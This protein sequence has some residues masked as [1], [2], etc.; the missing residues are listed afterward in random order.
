MASR[1]KSQG[2]QESYK[3]LRIQ[4][5]KL[6]PKSKSSSGSLTNQSKNNHLENDNFLSSNSGCETVSM[7]SVEH[8]STSSSFYREV[9]PISN[10]SS[11][12]SQDNEINSRTTDS[13]KVGQ[14]NTIAVTAE[15]KN[16]L[17]MVSKLQQ[18]VA[19]L[20]VDKLE[21]LRQ[22]V[23]VQREVKR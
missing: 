18:N 2:L 12:P 14:D 16:V 6:L 19:R 1:T 4:T 5:P 8:S 3:S 17:T 22:N 23:A 21:L 11:P 7:E 13:S 9:S 20:K 15:D 10:N